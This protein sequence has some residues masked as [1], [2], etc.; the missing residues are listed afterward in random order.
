[1]VSQPNNIMSF[2]VSNEDVAQFATGILKSLLQDSP[3]TI[4]MSLVK[5]EDCFVITVTDESLADIGTRLCSG[6]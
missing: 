1:M 6:K 3:L 2:L 5:L 4:T